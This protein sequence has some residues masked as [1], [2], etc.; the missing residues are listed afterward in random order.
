MRFSTGPC[1]YKLIFL[2]E[3]PDS[4]IPFADICPSLFQRVHHILHKMRQIAIL[5]NPKK[6]STE[7]GMKRQQCS[8]LFLPRR[9]CRFSRASRVSSQLQK[10]TC[11]NWH[12][13]KLT[14]IQCIFQ[15]WGESG[16]F[17]SWSRGRTMLGN[18]PGSF[19]S[20]PVAWVIVHF[21]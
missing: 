7:K 11:Q 16:G 1:I 12:I 18:Y 3:R 6:A 13:I 10:Q 2:L 20:A 14:H 19:E 4:S 21:K 9:P 17:L 8:L 15:S 5:A